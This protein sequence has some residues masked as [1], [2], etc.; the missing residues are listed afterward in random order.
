[1]KYFRL[2]DL[3]PYSL[4]PVVFFLIVLFSW[5]GYRYKK[6]RLKKH[7][8]EK[9]E[10]GRIQGGSAWYIISFNGLYVLRRYGKI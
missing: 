4:L 10:T 3:H 6:N 2:F 5:L 9:L 7:P 8:E 1:M